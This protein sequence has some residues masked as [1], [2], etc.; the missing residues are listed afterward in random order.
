MLALLPMKPGIEPS[1][2]SAVMSKK[3]NL[4]AGMRFGILVSAALA[5]ISVNRGSASADAEL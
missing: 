3:F 5:V 2:S 4:I 1:M